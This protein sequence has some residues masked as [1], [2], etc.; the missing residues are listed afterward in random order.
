MGHVLS[1]GSL[2]TYNDY[3]FILL[4]IVSSARPHKLVWGIN[5]GLE[6]RLKKAEDILFDFKDGSKMSI[7]NYLFETEHTT[8]ELFENRAVE[9]KGITKP[10]MLPELK[11]YDYFFKFGGNSDLFVLDELMEDLKSVPLIQY[12][13]QQEVGELTSRDNLIT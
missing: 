11:E 9:V 13:T 1:L 5:E 3:D 10:Y 4:A 8:V 6:I 12:V 7:S 2:D